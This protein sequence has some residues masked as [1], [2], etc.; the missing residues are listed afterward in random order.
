MSE[1]RIELT[2][3]AENKHSGDVVISKI[4]DI[5]A[6]A[7]VTHSFDYAGENWT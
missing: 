1:Y 4:N 5:L 2:I 3:V 7:N 6:N